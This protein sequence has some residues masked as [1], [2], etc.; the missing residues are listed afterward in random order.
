MGLGKRRTWQLKGQIRRR[1]QRVPNPRDGIVSEARVV[2]GFCNRCILWEWGRWL[3]RVH[4]EL[5]H[6]HPKLGFW[7]DVWTTIHLHL[8]TKV[9]VPQWFEGE[10]QNLWFF[11]PWVG[12][13]LVVIRDRFERRRGDVRPVRP[14]K[15]LGGFLFHC[16]LFL[17]E[18]FGCL[19]NEWVVLVCT[20]F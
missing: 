6:C 8:E 1:V 9:G 13:C 19:V 12:E 4:H 16:C 2:D 17:G 10:V 18:T 11:R 3:I 7:F 20:F 15:F 5:F 14:L